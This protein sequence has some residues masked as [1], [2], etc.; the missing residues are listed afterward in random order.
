[1]WAVTENFQRNALRRLPARLDDSQ[2]QLIL[3]GSEEDRQLAGKVGQ[4]KHRSREWHGTQQLLELGG[5]RTWRRA[6]GQNGLTATTRRR[7][8]ASILVTR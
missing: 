5:T 8:P 3:R 2:L 1:V 7:A 4:A 6:V